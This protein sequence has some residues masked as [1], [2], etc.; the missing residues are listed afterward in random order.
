MAIV[1][2]KDVSGVFAFILD[3]T[4]DLPLGFSCFVLPAAI[5][6]KVFNERRECMWYLAIALL[7]LGLFLMTVSTTVDSILFS[8]AC[9]WGSGCSSY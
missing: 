7:V 6:L 5:Y 8:V 2:A 9:I 1:P 3:I 4:G